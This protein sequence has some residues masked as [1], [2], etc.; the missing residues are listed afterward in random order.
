MVKKQALFTELRECI[1]KYDHIFVFTTQNM[2]NSPLK[3]LRTSWEGS[4]FYLGKNKIMQR[5]LGQREEEAHAENSH[6]VSAQLK[7]PDRGL[8]FTNKTEEEVRQFFADYSVPDYAR[9]GFL[10]SETVTIPAGKLTQFSHSLEP[11]LRSLGLPVSLKNGIIELSNDYTICQKDKR[12]TPEQARLLK[13]F[14][15]KMSRFVVVLCCHLSKGVFTNY[16]ESEE[17]E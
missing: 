7:G 4:R 10:A 8:L 6:L 12:L 5:S 2:R 13:L 15:V 17:E 3:V 1:D 16:L 9:S 11:H 14:E